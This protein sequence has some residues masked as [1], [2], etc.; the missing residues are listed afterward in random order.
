MHSFS[1]KSFLTVLFFDRVNFQHILYIFLEYIYIY[2]Y[3]YNDYQL[4]HAVTIMEYFLK[5]HNDHYLKNHTYCVTI[6]GQK[7]R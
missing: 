1:T 7:Q 6:D 3:I 5:P 2:I 4:E